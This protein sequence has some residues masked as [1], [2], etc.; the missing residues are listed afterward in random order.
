MSLLLGLL[1]LLLLLLAIIVV[2]G[3]L[4]ISRRI[5]MYN[6]SLFASAGRFNGCVFGFV[7]RMRA[8]VGD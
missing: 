6:H 2:A 8:G 1:L 7:S 5:H 4:L 3:H